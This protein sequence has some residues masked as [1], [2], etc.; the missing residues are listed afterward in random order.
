MGNGW[1]RED[2]ALVPLWCEDDVLPKDLVDLLEADSTL[3]EEDNTSVEADY[4][5]DESPF[6]FWFQAPE[7]FIPVFIFISEY[8]T[9]LYIEIWD[10]IE[11]HSSFWNIYSGVKCLTKVWWKFKISILDYIPNSIILDRDLVHDSALTIK[12]RY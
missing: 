3:N 4:D 1:K 12:K 5:S 9:A 10:L 8:H 6:E 11:E 2:D 7:F